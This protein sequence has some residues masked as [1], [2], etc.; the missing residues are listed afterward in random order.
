M[1][2][3]KVYETGK[4]HFATVCFFIGFVFDSLTLPDPSDPLAKYIGIFYLSL[5]AIFLLIREYIVTRN[6]ASKLEQRMYSYLTMGIALVTGALL[7]VIFIYY[8][9]SAELLVSWPLF[10]IFV[11]I[12][13]INELV[14]LHAFRFVLDLCVL[15]IALIFFSVFNI[16]L[17]IGEQNDTVF[18][19]SVFFATCISFIF[20]Y[21]LSFF[22]EQAKV[23]T[24]KAYA[25]AV[26]IPLVVMMLYFTNLIPA[27]P[28][29]LKAADVYHDIT[30][31]S[32]G[33]YLAVTEKDKGGIFTFWRNETLHYKEGGSVYFF[34]SVS[35]PNA[36]QA[37]L[38]HVW[39]YYDSTTNKWIEN[40][41]IKFPLTGGRE[42][43][44]RA[45]S[46]KNNVF[47]GLWRVSVKVGDKRIVGRKKFNIVIVDTPVEKE[48]I[49][50]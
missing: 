49:K 16:P 42:D 30:K 44:F 45:Y 4:E 11:I 5:L 26:A 34:S 25:I 23:F 2:L 43:G 28:L 48:Y 41:V 8:F 1:T 17:F 39:E 35:A 33:E 9:R 40:T 22:S 21:I 6:T 24:H 12:I 19:I 20:L 15:M 27:V 7:S 29:S 47:E 31:T 32:S 50:I 38:S 14:S 3:K 46:N 13:V 37:P 10:L 36:L 18:V